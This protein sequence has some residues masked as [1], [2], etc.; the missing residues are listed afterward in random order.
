MASLVAVVMEQSLGSAAPAPR[1]PGVA[2]REAKVPLVE[3]AAVV[4]MVRRVAPVDTATTPKEKA[5]TAVTA[6]LAVL[7]KKKEARAMTVML[8]VQTGAAREEA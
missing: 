4:L 5:A 1:V 8:V 7:A 2:A 3:H 6:M